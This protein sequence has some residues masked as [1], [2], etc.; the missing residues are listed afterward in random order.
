MA[1]GFIIISDKEWEK[2]A[3]EQ[4]DWMIFNTLKS[5][6]ARLSKLEN[7]QFYDGEALQE[8]LGHP[9]YQGVHGPVSIGQRGE[10]PGVLRQLQENGPDRLDGPI[11]RPEEIRPEGGGRSS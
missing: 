11:P 1:N 7:Q 5:I 8:P 9:L 4:R 10:H 6:D 3:P 2:S